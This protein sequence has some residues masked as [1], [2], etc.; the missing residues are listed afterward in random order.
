MVGRIGWGCD[1]LGLSKTITVVS[2]GLWA[3][4]PVV[5][6][7]GWGGDEPGLGKTNSFTVV[8]MLLRHKLPAPACAHG[9]P[10]RLVLREVGRCLGD[11]LAMCVPS[12]NCACVPSANC[13]CLPLP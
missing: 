6:R 13:A 8:S 4:L 3:A 1:D 5:G 9:Q 11:P 10:S 7:I 12:A 2:R